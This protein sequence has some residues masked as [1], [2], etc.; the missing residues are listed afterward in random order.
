MNDLPD[1]SM[2]LPIDSRVSAADLTHNHS[3]EARSRYPCQARV[4]V[5]FMYLTCHYISELRH[6]GSACTSM[7]P[8]GHTA[9]V[10]DM[11]SDR[12]V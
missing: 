9:R 6:L 1:T 5:R 7:M 4:H 10:Y 2:Q 12:N 11:C 3:L 8:T